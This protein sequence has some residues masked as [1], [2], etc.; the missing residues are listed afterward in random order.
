MYPI[1][2]QTLA[3]SAAS[4][5]FSSI[6]QNFTHLQLRAFQ[7]NTNSGSNEAFS[8]IAF[9][10]DGSST[11]YSSQTVFGNGSSVTSFSSISAPNAFGPEAPN[12][13]TTA[14]VY[15]AGIVDIFDYTN[16]V[17][18][19]TFK[20]LT[21]FDS[22]G[23]GFVFLHSGCWLQT[24]AITSI[25]IVSAGTAFKAGSNYQLYG[26]TTSNVGSF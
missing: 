18:N 15:A 6:P 23:F 26:I 10:G 16:T 13:G 1:A 4:I 14:N 22:N 25:T 21:G 12:D 17:T 24:S 9:N 8:T 19:K 3:S 5:T 11:H 2:T 7:R 20:T